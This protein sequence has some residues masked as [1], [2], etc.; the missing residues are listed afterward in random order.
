M[1]R[2]IHFEIMVPNPEK[3]VEFYEKVFGWQIHKFEH[4]ENYY[5]V[6]T[7]EGEGIGGAIM[8]S[9][10]GDARTVNTI[11]VPSVDEYIAIIEANGGKALT[12]KIEIP[13]VGHFANVQDP[14]GLI[15]GIIELNAR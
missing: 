11:D 7:G 14:E 3:A 1:K 15:F 8:K 5:L 10:H 12:P 6:N 9:P 4:E 2:P 13:G